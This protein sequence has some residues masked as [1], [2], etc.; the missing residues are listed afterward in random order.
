MIL[1]I[2][3]GCLLGPTL[4]INM[5]RVLCRSFAPMRI[6]LVLKFVGMPCLHS[7]PRKSLIILSND[8]HLKEKTLKTVGKS[9]TLL[10]KSAINKMFK[11]QLSDCE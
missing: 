10:W 7:L 11:S 6:Q 1:D 9:Y 8:V 5:M 4:K 3:Q 2:L